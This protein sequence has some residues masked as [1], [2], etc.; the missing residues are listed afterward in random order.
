VVTLTLDGPPGRLPTLAAVVP[1]YNR[2][3]YPVAG[4]DLNPLVWCLYS[5]LHQIGSGLRRIVVVNDGSTDHTDQIVHD[6]AARHAS[7]PVDIEYL[8]NPHRTGP[9]RARNR[10]LAA[11]DTEQV[12]FLDD[13]CVFVDNQAL[14]VAQRS[15]RELAAAGVRVGGLHLPVFLRADDYPATTSQDRIGKI[16]A[17]T[18][19]VYANFS[20]YPAEHAALRHRTDVAVAVPVDFLQE[21]FL[22]DTGLLTAAG[23]FPDTGFGAVHHEGVF[24]T[25]RLAHT[26]PAGLALSHY[27]LVHPH[28]G[29]IHFRYGSG[30]TAP[31]PRGRWP[32][33]QI[34]DRHVPFAVMLDE[35]AVTRADTGGRATPA[36]IV[37][38]IIAGRYTQLLHLDQHGAAAFTQL[39]YDA[40]VHGE[41]P[42]GLFRFPP[43]DLDTAGRVELWTAA[44]QLGRT[45]YD[46]QLAGI[47][48]GAHLP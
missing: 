41:D 24:L 25:L 38:D 20:H 12:F 1:T 3:P 40:W 26:Q 14:A 13:D 32:G 48:P 29:L 46:Q 39:A 8:V 30:H 9:C 21:V 5:L 43:V 35:A 22:A 17:R 4:Y 34:E 44:L 18:G 33:L 16:H 31:G 37:V 47:R 7:G 42:L 36:Q 2:C 6:V 45:I 19:A 11:A 28:V 10:G 15:H 27:Q 23:G